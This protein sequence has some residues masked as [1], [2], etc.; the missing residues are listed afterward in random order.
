MAQHGMWQR[1]CPKCQATFSG[2]EEFCPHDG[3]P[4]LL[5][6]SSARPDPLIGQTLD[7]RFL[8]EKVLG[9]GG[10]GVVYLARHRVLQRPFALKLL[11]RELV[12]DELARRRFQREARVASAIVHPNIV[13]IYD[14]GQTPQGQAYLVME[15][16]DGLSLHALAG[17]TPRRQLHITQA[18][19]ITMQ[20]V[21]ALSVA[22]TRGIVHRDIKPENILLL[23]RS[24]QP[25]FVKVTD[26]GVA[27][28]LDEEVRLTAAGSLVGTPE[29]IAP[30]MLQSGEV[31]PAAD[32]YAVGVMMHELIAGAPPFTGSV[33]AILTS[34]LNERAPSL[35][36]RCP[37]L[38]IPKELD[39]LVARLLNKAPASRLTADETLGTLMQLRP[40]L[41][42]RSVRSLLLMETLVLA[43]REDPIHRAETLLLPQRGAQL[44]DPASRSAPAASPAPEAP[45]PMPSSMPSSIP[46]GPGPAAALPLLGEM[47]QLDLELERTSQQLVRL[48][49]ALIKRRWPSRPPPEIAQKCAHLDACEKADEDLGLRLALLRDEAEK[50]AQ[51]GEARRQELHDQMLRVREQI[52]A[53]GQ[54]EGPARVQAE[55]ALRDALLEIE[56]LYAA[57]KFD[58]EAAGQLSQLRPRQ[59]EL[60]SE[61]QR[62]RR[63]LGALVL[64]R[65]KIDSR[66]NYDRTIQ[67]AARGLEKVLADYD[68]LCSTMT[69]LLGRLSTTPPI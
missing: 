11:R 10:M 28:I 29:F 47:D 48:V 40:R 14:Y 18:V 45:S 12:G 53:A 20:V 42:P 55:R 8:I 21:Q 32:L 50:Q 19:D 54:A 51:V 24:G 37:E 61:I 22:H 30:E 6:R 25:D 15:Y 34:H 17:K 63:E 38:G 68:R 52:E 13:G 26:F 33:N 35:S 7:G 65:C 49:L 69:L 56:R 41:P 4:L 1:V 23:S 36:Q 60:R 46:S 67:V 5:P 44:S 27:R 66:P 59:Q 62:T 64:R 2:V 31:S 58:G 16:V 3:S 9:Q 43:G 39:A 57:V